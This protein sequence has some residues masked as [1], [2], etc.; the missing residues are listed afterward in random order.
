MIRDKKTIWSA[1]ILLFV[2]VSF[3]YIS[4]P[5]QQTRSQFHSS[6]LEKITVTSEGTERTDYVDS[7]GQLTIA[8]DL[9]YATVIATKTDNSK[10]EQYFDN[11]GK[12]ISRYSG[13]YALLQEYD[14]K[15]NNIRVLYLDRNSESMSLANG[16]AMEEREYNEK[17]QLVSVRH[18]DMEGNPICTPA[19]G[20]GRINEYGNDGKIH[21]IIYLDANGAPMMT[22]QGYAI[23]TRN[24]Y[25][26]GP[27]N[28]KVESEFYFDETGNPIS[29]SLSQYGV[30][31]E[32][33]E[34]GRES[35]LTYLDANGNPIVTTK[36]YTTVIRTF[37]VDNS[38]ATERYFDIDGNPFSLSEGQ[39]GKKIENGKTTYLN[40]NGVE[41]FNIRT[42]LYNHSYLV[43]LFALVIVLLSAF[44]ENRWN[45]LLLIIYIVAIAYITLMYR[46]GEGGKIKL[47][48]FWSYKNIISNSESRA[49]ILKNI[50]LFVPLGAILYRFYPR[51]GILLIPVALSIFI[52]AIQYFA[53]IGIC[54][55][56]DV[57][58]NGLGGVIGFV[59]C[60]LLCES[61]NVLFVRSHC[62][63]KQ[64]ARTE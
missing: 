29:L 46:E 50:W 36:G 18:L 6:E 48:L 63:L 19:Y 41:K 54:E 27:E 26:D 34:N 16:C 28:G 12:P 24:Y 4:S 11:L 10:L 44:L 55:F 9:G 20:Y 56:D 49:D 42:L 14:D 2:V 32:Y 57:I 30:H 33:D 51:I 40:A 62:S 45:L 35:V 43:I 8:A 5:V 47:E 15:G 1:L 52:E 21:R 37:Q 31:K 39:Y 7:N 61:K 60:R 22:A 25:K 17:G 13:Y 64:K 53:K 38:V 23:A 3:M 58:S 59:S